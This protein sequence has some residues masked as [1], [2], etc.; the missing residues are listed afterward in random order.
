MH[1]HILDLICL[2]SEANIWMVLAH[3]A[4]KREDQLVAYQK[5][6]EILQTASQAK[7]VEVPQKLLPSLLEVS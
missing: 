4:A 7:V 6:A 1:S 5:A 2:E 3:A